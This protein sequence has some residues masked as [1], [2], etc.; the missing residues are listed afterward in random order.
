[1]FEK[2]IGKS[3]KAVTKGSWPAILRHRKIAAMA[4][5]YVFADESGNFDFSRKQGATTYFILT[6]VTMNDGAVAGALAHLRRELA[7]DG[8][9]LDG[10]PF[11]CAE[12]KQAVRDR[13]FQT[14]DAHSF[15][16]DATILEKAK[17]QPQLRATEQRFYQYAWY[18]HMKYITRLICSANDRLLVVSAS[19]GGKP[20][21]VTAFRAAVSDVINQFS[22]A[23]DSHV[24][25][26]SAATEPGLQVADY[27]AWAI[28]RKWE[29]G[30]SRSYDL[31]KA[32]IATEFAP[33]DA[34]QVRYY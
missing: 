30:D 5:V 29:R 8:I 18:F 9:G 6:T 28:Q 10:K 13:V 23:V 7:C 16:I 14:L 33:F 26:W 24:A 15:R 3:I 27:C 11:H 2:T 20:T 17:A 1:M 22:P 31:I 12:E 4:M 34:G 32:K 19:I 25:A 21:R